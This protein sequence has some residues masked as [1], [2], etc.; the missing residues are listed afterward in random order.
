MQNFGITLIVLVDPPILAWILGL[1]G[2]ALRLLNCLN[3]KKK[4]F[5]IKS[6]YFTLNIL[7]N[8]HLNY[9]INST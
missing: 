6:A 9:D 5:G 4:K 8:M 3:G 7:K 2:F 1:K